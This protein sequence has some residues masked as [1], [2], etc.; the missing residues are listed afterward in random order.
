M[1]IAVM[2]CRV[3]LGFGFIV[4][5]LNIMHPFLPQ[6]PPE[7]GSL[8]AQFMAVMFPTH[9]ITVVGFFQALGGV[10]VLLGRTAPLGLVILAPILVNILLFHVCLM[11]GAGILPGLVFSLFE[12]VLLFAY[13]SHFQPL[14]STSARPNIG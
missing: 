11:G 7:P 12:I 8:P 6:P 3:L 10:L 9:Y 2:I 1:K 5:G 4:F 13:R 14:L